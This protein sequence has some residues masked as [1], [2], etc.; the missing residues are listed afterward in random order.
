MSMIDQCFA[1]KNIKK[2][3]VEHIIPQAL[4]GKFKARL[5]C[6]NCNDTFGRELD[7][8]LSINYGKIG[9]LLN[10][11]RER[12]KIQAFDVLETSTQTPLV[13]TGK[14]I[15]RKKPTVILKLKDGKNLEFADVTA[16]TQ[17]EL[18]KIKATLKERYEMSD[19][20][21]QETFREDRPGPIDAN[22]Q[23]TIDNISIRRAIS[24]IAYS[25]LCT[26]IPKDQILSSSF[27]GIRNYIK[28]GTGSDLASA[29]YIHTKFMTD[30]SRPLHKI[31]I[32]LNRGKFMVVGFVML[33]GIYRFS[34]LLSD[35]LV[36]H[37]DWPDLDYTFDP[38]RSRYVYGNDRFRVPALTKENILRPK[39]L[40]KFVFN[41]LNTGL[42]M[43]EN[44]AEKIKFVRSDSV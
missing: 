9:T 10:I 18:E 4:G 42:K 27:E 6:K 39:Q 16:R 31:H 8:I 26:K 43:L 12:G 37:L 38:V 7:D 1:C 13:F 35:T 33:F 32:A 44:Y 29:N 23:I 14:G 34:V 40:K 21:E 15:S 20:A 2:L 41:E 30:Y 22:F 11:K 19:S 17:K 24:K 25:F 3:T 36:S 28:D 5:Y